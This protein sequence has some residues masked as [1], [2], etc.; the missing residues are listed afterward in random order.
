MAWN[1]RIIVFITGTFKMIHPLGF[2]PFNRRKAIFWTFF[3]LTLAFFAVFQVLDAPLKTTA[4]SGIVSYE[5]ARTPETATAMVAS[6]DPRARHFVAFG[7]G[8]DF[9]FM[10]VYAI[11]LS[12]GI[13]L[14]AGRHRGVWSALGN[15]LGWGAFAAV[16]FDMVEN[17]A[18]FSILNGSVAANPQIAFWCANLKFGLLLSGMLYGLIGWLFPQR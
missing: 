7:L 3:L 15:A 6:W 14:A 17:I 12:A 13:L 16:G 1:T 18:L 10:P 2:I 11:A 9:L 5:L 8:L 4:S